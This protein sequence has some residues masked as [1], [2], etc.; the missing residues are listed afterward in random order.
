MNRIGETVHVT[1]A[2]AWLL[3]AVQYFF[4]IGLSYGA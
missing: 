4:V 1:R 2:V 3:S